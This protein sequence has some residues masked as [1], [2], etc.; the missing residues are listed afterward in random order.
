MEQRTLRV[1]SKMNPKYSRF[2][3]LADYVERLSSLHADG[4]LT[5]HE[6]CIGTTRLCRLHH[7]TN[8]N[9]IT[10]R[11]D[12]TTLLQKTNGHIT[13]YNEYKT[14]DTMHQP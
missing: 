13:F 7:R 11:L 4:Y 10:L 5:M 8:G 3:M 6:T 14:T 12:A 9:T 2:R 1:N